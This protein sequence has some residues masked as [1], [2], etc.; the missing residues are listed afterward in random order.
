MYGFWPRLTP[1]CLLLSAWLAACPAAARQPSAAEPPLVRILAAELERNF[2][3]LREKADPP[4]YFISYRVT[5]TD[6]GTLAAS[7]GALTQRSQ[8]RRRTLDVSVRVGDRQLDNFHLLKGERPRFTAST[9]LPVEDSPAAIARLAWRQTDRAWRA[10]AQ[11]LTQIRSEVK[12]RTA[13]PNTAELPDFSEEEAATAFLD[14]PSPRFG[15]EEWAAKLRKWSAQFSEYRSLIS[16]GISLQWQREIR[17][18][19]TTEGTRIQHGRNF[20]RLTVSATAKAYDGNDYSTYESFDAEDPARLPREADIVAAVRKVGEQLTALLRAP[21]AEPYVGPAILSGRAAGVFFHEIFG[22]RIEGH[23][24]RDETE[25]QTFAGSVGKPVLPEFLSV[26][27]DPLLKTAAGVDLNGWYA[28]DDEGVPA[29]RVPVVEN[30]VLR[31]FLVSR[32]PIPGFGRSNG[33][34][35]AQPGMEPVSRQSNLVVESSKKVSRAELRRLLQAEIRRQNKP[36]G[37]YFEQVTGGFTTTRRGGL[38]AFTVIPLVVYRVFA[39]GRPDELIRGADIVGTPLASF[40]KI[41]ATADEPEVFNGYCGAESG[42][43]PV[44]AVSPALLVEEI[45]IQRKPE[46]KDIPPILPRPAAEV[47]P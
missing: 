25:G 24:M 17:T 1:T 7:L 29:R 11:R 15:A 20:Y 41:L 18:L 6:G 32:L 39:D 8:S 19:V 14:T 36:Y 45:E 21:A 47:R 43:V 9:Q 27:S 44:S 33:H 35:R 34:G 4:P 22:H 12:M 16:S 40:A 13:D 37:L 10:A 38:Q 2:T 30:G 31:N 5:E 3:V 23:R 26:V 42:S 28:F 46:S